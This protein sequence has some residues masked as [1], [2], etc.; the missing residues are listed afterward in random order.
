MPPV[1]KKIVNH[2]RVNGWRGGV[3]KQV[4]R[5][6]DVALL[7]IGFCFAAEP[8]EK[9]QVGRGDSYFSARLQN[10]ETFAQHGFALMERDVLNH[11]FAEHIIKRGGGNG[12]GFG[13]IE[14]NHALG[15][16][17]RVAAVDFGVEPAGLIVEPG[18]DLQLAHAVFAEVIVYFVF[19]AL[20][21]CFGEKAVIHFYGHA[22]QQAVEEVEQG[23]NFAQQEIWIVCRK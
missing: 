20:L 12:K 21:K 17:G 11:V 8:D 1:V 18:S 9:A 3:A 22:Q 7:H 6:A 5:P 23:L 19:C 15:F 16:R 14:K 10:A 4:V 13:G 2:K